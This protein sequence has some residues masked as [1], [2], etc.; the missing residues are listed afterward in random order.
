VQLAGTLYFNVST[1]VATQS[2]LAAQTAHQHVWRPDAI[3][4]VCFLVA[5][6]LAWFEVCHGPVAWRPHSWSW[7]ITL[8]NLIGSVAFGVSA[9][10]GYVNP[11]TGQ[12]RNAGGANLWTLVGA[13]CFFAGAVLLL[14]ER[15]EKT[16]GEV[17]VPGDGRSLERGRAAET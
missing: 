14:P 3:G 6:V 11:V 13:V 15:T 17:I 8:A 10:A 4:S 7:W 12:V 2:D 9:V 16:S 5:S 1:G